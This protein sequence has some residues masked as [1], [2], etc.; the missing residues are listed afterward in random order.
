LPNQR[1]PWRYGD[2]C[3]A[4][5]VVMF[6]PSGQP[7]VGQAIPIMQTTVVIFQRAPAP[8]IGCGRQ[9]RVPAQEAEAVDVGR[10]RFFFFPKMSFQLSL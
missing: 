1:H 3:D 10:Y 6:E 2:P 9:R 8:A 4:D 5:K 7:I